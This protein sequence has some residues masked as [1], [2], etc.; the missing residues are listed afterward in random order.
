M[1]TLEEG[2]SCPRAEECEQVIDAANVRLRPDHCRGQQGLDL[3]A[4]EQPAVNLRVMERAD[5][6]TVPTQDQGPAGAVPERDGKLSPRP[7]E[8]RFSQ[9][10]VKVDPRL[11]V[12]VGRQ[13]MSPRQE[14]LPQFGILEQ[15]AV[16]GNPDR[17]ILVGEW[18]TAPCQID[19]RQA[20]G[21]QGHPW[22]DVDLLVI[23]AP[24]SDR[25][26]HGQKSSRGEFPAASQVHSACNTAHEVTSSNRPGRRETAY[27]R[28][29]P[30]PPLE[31]QANNVRSTRPPQV[32]AGGSF[33]K[34][35]AWLPGRNRDAAVTE[36]G[37]SVA[38]ISARAPDREGLDGMSSRRRAAC[39]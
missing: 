21:S 27:R 14:I 32:S 17:S 29:A 30:A 15:L 37:H 9:V 26:R 28:S 22:L 1:D 5:A 18:L 2:T 20:P 7:D 24:M 19:D 23:R 31:E 38:R 12:A 36:H 11:G 13:P 10:L 33:T 34:N 6:H 25:C 39:R 35:R 8:H 3:R 4:P 16:E